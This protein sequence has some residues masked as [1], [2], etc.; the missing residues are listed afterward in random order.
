MSRGK[1]KRRDK[2]IYETPPPG[3]R[4]LVYIRFSG[5]DQDAASQEAAVRRWATETM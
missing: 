5:E 3:S 1:Y 4:M 2:A